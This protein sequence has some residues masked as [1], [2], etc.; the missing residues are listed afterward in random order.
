MPWWREDNEQWAN[1]DWAQPTKKEKRNASIAE[2]VKIVEMLLCSQPNVLRTREK[3]IWTTYGKNINETVEEY[4][5][6]GT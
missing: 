4:K 1:E 3:K 2:R 5:N 6:I